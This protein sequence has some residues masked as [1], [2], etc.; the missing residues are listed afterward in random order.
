MKNFKDYISGDELVLVDFFAVWCGPCKVMHNILEEYKSLVGSNVRILKLDID[1]K[2]NASKVR[3]YNVHSV[4]TLMFFRGGEI[5]WRASGVTSVAEL[6]KL[7]DK[8][9]EA[10]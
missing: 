6:K 4:P 10:R 1:A 2:I 9:L 7:S 3:E 8:L 5:L